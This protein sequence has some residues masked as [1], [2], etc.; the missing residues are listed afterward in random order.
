MRPYL[1]AFLTIGAVTMLA[2]GCAPVGFADPGAGGGQP[3][4]DAGGSES[5]SAGA[6]ASG[7]ELSEVVPPRKGPVSVAT[8]L[9]GDES[10]TPVFLSIP[11]ARSM[12]SAAQVRGILLGASPA[13]APLPSLVHSDEIFNYH[14]LTYPAS[15][16]S[17]L[18]L[19]TELVPTSVDGDYLLQ[20]GVQAPAGGARRRPT[21]LTVLVD[22]SKSMQGESMRRANAA[23]RALAASLNKGDVLTYL[24]TD[25][26]FEVVT[27]HAE[28]DGDPDLF[29]QGSDRIGVGGSGTLGERVKQAYELATMQGNYVGEGLNRVVVITDGGGLAGEIDGG[30]VAAHWAS[31]EIELVGVGV[32]SAVG[33]HEE[34]LE[35][36][37]RAGHGANLYLDSVEE[38]DRA[39]HQRFDEVM[40]E[41]A[42]DVSVSFELPWLF[43]SIHPDASGAGESETSLT[44]SALG[45]GRSMVFRHTVSKCPGL[46]LKGMPDLSI[47]VTAQ[48]TAP[49][50]PERQSL[51]QKIRM[52]E[53]LLDQPS[54]QILKA[55]AILA[56]GNALLSLD[57]ARFKDACAK[58]KKARAGVA[59]LPGDPAAQD[60][61]LD[62][63]LDLLR[64]H[65]LVPKGPCD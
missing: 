50:A 6:G 26:K 36:A 44:R 32:G 41:V 62:S 47:V 55:S 3:T 61:E 29:P 48:W 20:I 27:R 56:Y 9:P 34:L 5:G 8:C 45:R 42:S 23:V 40:D 51:T 59:M 13:T 11:R 17:G 2:L 16:T 19:V 7:P 14:H 10:S 38:A 31:E 58:V 49:G 37:T 15:A 57:T 30:L 4:G 63:I 18:T 65:P 39:L 43:K 22:S 25:E 46:P 24:T 52:T 21:S 28:S 53:A 64:R 1:E 35:A 12:T 33:Y 60:P 54:P